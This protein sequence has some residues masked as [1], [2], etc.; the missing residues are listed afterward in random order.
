MEGAIPSECGD[1]FPV[2]DSAGSSPA[3]A[4][5]FDLPILP[6]A[7]IIVEISN[8][9]ALYDD[10]GRYVSPGYELSVWQKSFR[11]QSFEKSSYSY[12]WQYSHGIRKLINGAWHGQLGTGEPDL[13]AI[14]ASD[15]I[16]IVKQAILFVMQK[17]DLH[18]D[19]SPCGDCRTVAYPN[20]FASHLKRFEH[21]IIGQANSGWFVLANINEAF[22][23]K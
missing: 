8:Y 7:R 21:F 14:S 17:Y 15:Q 2:R 11:V 18:S 4:K 16:R 3:P 9:H 19:Y 1:A 10:F 20:N 5:L 23:S 12:P 22:V 6:S 13:I